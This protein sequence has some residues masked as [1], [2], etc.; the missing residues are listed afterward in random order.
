[1]GQGKDVTQEGPYGIWTH[2]LCDTDAALY[3]YVLPIRAWISTLYPYA[4][5][6]R[7][8]RTLHPGLI[9]TNSLVV[10]ITAKIDSIFVF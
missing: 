6:V 1:M 2:D 5:P 9:S 10:F 4:L 8:T 3:L 7:S